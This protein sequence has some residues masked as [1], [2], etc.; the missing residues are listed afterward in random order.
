MGCWTPRLEAACPEC[1]LDDLVVR[2]ACPRVTSSVVLMRRP[3]CPCW[4]AL[5]PSALSPYLENQHSLES[6]YRTE[7]ALRCPPPHRLWC[8][9]A[10]LGAEREPAACHALGRVGR[11]VLQYAA[12]S[13]CVRSNYPPPAILAG[14]PPA[15]V[16]LAGRYCC[17]YYS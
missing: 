12:L 11:Q 8:N 6:L 10:L 4:V 3:L 7:M 16:G 2:R 5:S 15:V 9:K 1:L 14:D 17:L 13:F